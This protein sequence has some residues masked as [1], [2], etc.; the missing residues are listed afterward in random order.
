MKKIL[1]FSLV[2]VLVLF[3]FVKVSYAKA[4]PWTAAGSRDVQSNTTTPELGPILDAGFNYKS[5]V[6]GTYLAGDGI[7]A[8]ALCSFRTGSSTEWTDLVST[9]ESYGTTLLDLMVNGESN[10]GTTCSPDHTYSQ[11]ITGDG[12]MPNL[13]ILDTYPSNNTGLLHVEFYK[14]WKATGGPNSCTT[15]QSGNILYSAGHFL[16]D[17]PIKPGFDI[18]GYNYQAHLFSGSYFNAYA[19]GAGFPPYLGDDTAYLTDSPTAEDHWAWPY[20]TTQVLMK[21]NDAWLANTDCDA[22]GK[23]DR[24]YGYPS[25]RGSGAWETNHMW[26][27]YPD[28]EDE[29]VI[30]KWNDFYKIVAVPTDATLIDGTWYNAD[31]GKI[32]TDIW[33]EFAI[34]Q[35][36][37]NDQGTGDHG[38]LYKSPVGPGFG[39]Y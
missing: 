39:K 26:D 32:G 3:A 1:L 36:V 10:W 8:D 9:Y 21:W 7:E 28:T 20:R 22:D 35:E 30:Y 33:G 6:T 17:T 18:F 13:F 24:H 5:V 31:G 2:F 38:V 37:Y 14:F 34:I 15:L 4:E 19:G 11:V 29:T 25:Y 12:T 23:L 16:A 27:A